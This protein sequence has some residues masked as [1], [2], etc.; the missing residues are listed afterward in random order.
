MQQSHFNHSVSQTA[1]ANSAPS[2][3]PLAFA[4]LTVRLDSPVPIYQQV[5]GAVRA[6]I[7]SGE[8]P[9]GTLL[10]T[11]RELAGV[12]GIA[13]NTVVNAYARL[14]AEGHVVSNKRRGTRV[15][16]LSFNASAPPRQTLTA[17]AAEQDSHRIEIAQRAQHVLE[18]S[19]GANRRPFSLHATDPLLS[20]RNLMGRLLAEEFRRPPVEDLK[21]GASHGTQR[22]QMA[23]AGYLRQMRGVYCNPEQI[24]PTT[25]LETALD[26]AIR[27][28][29]DPGHSIY[30]ENPAPDSVRTAFS[31]AG[32][33]LYPL[34]TAH[35]SSGASNMIK[36]PRLIFVSPSV[37]FP[38]GQQ[39]PQSERLALLELA[40]KTNALIFENDMYGELT[41]SGL[42]LQA[43]QGQDPLGQ[44]L[45]FGSLTETLGPHIRMGFL[46]VPAPLVESFQAMAQRVS[47][48][49]EQ[50]ILSAVARLLE[51]N[52]YAMHVRL[53]RSKYAK[54][55]QTM[56]QVCRT[57]LR[58]AS[59]IEPLG[60]LHV[61]LRFEQ[62]LNEAGLC[63]QAAAQGLAVSPL[64]RFYLQPGQ[65]CGLVL[66]FGAM[67]ERTIE[68]AI[69]RLAS[70]VDQQL[71][72]PML[73]AS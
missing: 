1:G 26:L 56:I 55:M 48:G 37:N 53:I 54:R 59:V 23:L 69:R 16:P 43:I 47:Y 19:N 35:S 9:Q 68:P 4:N 31:A 30:I 32:A 8:L 66:G 12:L 13:R 63:V 42:R 3:W 49:P 58:S 7:T 36:P 22:I 29:I 20:P 34:D 38:F 24:F 73:R 5:L 46:V 17:S 51:E 50:F 45:Y 64:S 10:P 6:A 15:A 25:S 33:R 39:L 71:S 60:G 14:A 28:L 40:A 61:A 57:H 65:I 27:V 72:A 52:R 21:T 70:L 44:V 18:A 62:A 67:A 41:Y 2:N 11:S